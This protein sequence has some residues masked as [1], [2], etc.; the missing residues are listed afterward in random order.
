MPPLM[1]SWIKP[2]DQSVAGKV[3]KFMNINRSEAGE[4]TCEAS[5]VCGNA[6]EM[7][8]I[9]VQCKHFILKKTITALL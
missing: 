3:L 2:N 1:V 7:A 6:T 5:N 8:R 9:D 4:Y